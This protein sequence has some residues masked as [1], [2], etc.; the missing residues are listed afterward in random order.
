MSR[1]SPPTL[2]ETLPGG[3]PDGHTP[4]RLADHPRASSSIARVRAWGALVAFAVAAWL[5]YR[6]GL[7]FVDLVARSIVFGVAGWLVAWA[8]AQTVWR[9]LVY[10]EVAAAR[11]RAT[12]AQQAILAE[13]ADAAEGAAGTGRAD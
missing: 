9:Q 1:K 8:A 13:L 10:A 11:R 12:E 2:D 7:P 5:G 3:A 6:M 4:I